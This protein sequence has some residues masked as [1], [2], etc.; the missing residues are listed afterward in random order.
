MVAE[1]EIPLSILYVSTV[2]YCNP[3]YDFK[4]LMKRKKLKVDNSK[5][6]EPNT[7]DLDIKVSMS[8]AVELIPET[9]DFL[10]ES[11]RLTKYKE[12]PSTADHLSLHKSTCEISVD[13][14]ALKITAHENEH[15]HENEISK[16][17]ESGNKNCIIPKIF[18]RISM[19]NSERE[20]AIDEDV[21]N[22]KLGINKKLNVVGFKP[23]HTN[24]EIVL[25]EE[26]K[27]DKK[28]Y[29]SNKIIDVTCKS[30]TKKRNE[31]HSEDTESNICVI[32]KV[33]SLN[34]NKTP[35]HSTKEDIKEKKENSPDTMQ[36]QC[37]SRNK[38]RINSSTTVD[39]HTKGYIFTS[40]KENTLAFT[41]KEQLNKWGFKKTERE[42][43]EFDVNNYLCNVIGKQDVEKEK[44]VDKIHVHELI[45]QKYPKRFKEVDF[46]KQT[47]QSGRATFSNENVSISLYK[48]YDSSLQNNS[49]F[50]NSDISAHVSVQNNM[51]DNIKNETSVGN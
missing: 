13:K 43:H 37:N 48:T 36:F 33:S 39:I 23:I 3:K 47:T 12:G 24:V 28:H 5:V 25:E 32:T 8:M 26:A 30:G 6:L 9:H 16:K 15:E 51:P 45:S 20:F 10:S 34:V 38:K 44:K 1:T 22:K 35:E 4:D 2:K 17:V 14:T 21:T 31:K 29:V 50:W 7:Q 27:F 18:K 42:S 49:T 41:K 46:Q 19:Q 11:E 40:R